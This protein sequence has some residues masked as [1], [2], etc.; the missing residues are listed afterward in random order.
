MSPL[1][2]LFISVPASIAL[3]TDS[4]YPLTCF[5]VGVS[6]PES[7]LTSLLF[8]VA[9]PQACQS[10]CKKRQEDCSVWTWT[11]SSFPVFPDACALYNST[12]GALECNHCI[13]G[14]PVCLCSTAG[15]CQVE[16]DN[17]LGVEQ[18]VEESECQAI[19]SDNE[20]CNFYSWFSSTSP[21]SHLCMLFSSCASVDI[22][23]YGCFTGP[24]DCPDLAPTS[25]SLPTDPTTEITTTAVTSTTTEEPDEVCS[26]TGQCRVTE[27]NLLNTL[28]NVTLEIDCKHFCVQNEECSVYTWFGDL[29]P[30]SYLCMLFSSCDFEDDLCYDC[31]T[32]P[33]NCP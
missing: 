7:S 17:F 18:S 30:L 8:E 2:L 10:Q 25:P 16:E 28:A 24:S 3:P 23:C 9:T 14:P 21:L 5:S 12:E 6:Y 11:D 13:S 1:V 29:N 26:H 19:C 15:Q 22:T 31:F 33:P 20:E 32:G 4:P 27:M